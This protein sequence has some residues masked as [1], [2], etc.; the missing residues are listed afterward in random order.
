MRYKSTDADIAAASAKVPSSTNRNRYNRIDP[1]PPQM[2]QKNLFDEGYFRSTLHDYR[3]FDHGQPPITF[4]CHSSPV[5]YSSSQ[6]RY[7]IS[8]YL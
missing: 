1:K 7:S 2:I 6:S 3:K 4:F 8:L 5:V